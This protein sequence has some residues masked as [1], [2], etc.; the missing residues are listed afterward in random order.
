VYDIVVTE[1]L[2][3][4]ERGSGNEVFHVTRERAHV[5]SLRV[6]DSA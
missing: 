1:E 5:K 4:E 6:D 2:Q 3:P